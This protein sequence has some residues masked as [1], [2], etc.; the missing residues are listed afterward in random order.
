MSLHAQPNPSHYIFI[1][2]M[3]TITRSFLV[4]QPLTMSRTCKLE[5]LLLQA[6]L[7]STI[8]LSYPHMDEASV[9]ATLSPPRTLRPSL[10][11][12]N[13]QNWCWRRHTKMLL[14]LDGCEPRETLIPY[15]TGVGVS[16]TT[17][18]ITP[19][20]RGKQVC[21]SCCASE[22][23]RVVRRRY[24]FVCGGRNET[25]AVFFQLIEKCGFVD[26]NAE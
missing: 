8:L 5:Y 7:V 24:Q 22:R 3:S 25:R 21:I 19:G 26:C 9:T 11:D 6:A 12:P 16:F 1:M 13:P 15:C 18:K 17:P 4:Q 2:H 10:R 23:H 14:H 20:P